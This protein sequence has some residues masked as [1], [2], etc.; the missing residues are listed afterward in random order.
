MVYP[1]V[2]RPLVFKILR[3]QP[4][5]FYL[6]PQGLNQVEPGRRSAVGSRAAGKKV[7]YPKIFVKN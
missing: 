6:P 5:M 2:K 1:H 3:A 4:L 7:L